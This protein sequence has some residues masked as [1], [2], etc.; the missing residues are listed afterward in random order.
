MKD[1]R[2]VVLPSATGRPEM[3]LVHRPAHH[4]FIRRHWFAFCTVFVVGVGL[5]WTA[6]AYRQ[7][8]ALLGQL[9][10][11]SAGLNN[12]LAQA[13]GRRTELNRQ[14]DLL[15]SDTYIEMLARQRFGLIK[16]GE[17]PFTTRTPEH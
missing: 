14:Q 2:L 10:H 15:Q 9:Q 6:N 3:K 1:K 8:A 5:S 17:T 11:E 7:Q 4:G 12:E 16:S 13:R